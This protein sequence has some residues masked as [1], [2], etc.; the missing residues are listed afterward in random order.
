MNQFT[1]L[2]PSLGLTAT[3]VTPADIDAAIREVKYF[4]AEEGI[5]GAKAF[6]LEDSDTP[7]GLVHFNAPAGAPLLTFC[8][9][10]L[11]NG[12]VVTGKSVC[13]DPGNY[14][15]ELGQQFALKDA[16]EQMWLILGVLLK[17]RLASFPDDLD[18]NL[19]P[20]M[21]RV[22]VEKHELDTRLAALNK[23]TLSPAFNT[24]PEREMELLTTQESCM[25]ELSTIL[26]E[27]LSAATQQ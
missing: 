13:A 25:T 18:R 21:M 17:D 5:Y 19:P 23:F 24:L 16:K 15:A 8:L 11:N 14:D 12:L 6:R 27:R 7:V 4:T 10:E 2:A 22:Q 20:H 9:L 26:G 1:P 3:K